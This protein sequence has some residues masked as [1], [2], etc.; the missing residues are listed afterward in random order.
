MT[1]I[2]K[3]DTQESSQFW[4]HVESVAERVRTSE[5]YANHRVP[6]ENDRNSVEH[7]RHAQEAASQPEPCHFPNRN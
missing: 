4:S 2:K 7:R 6:Q 5:V 1:W 3:K